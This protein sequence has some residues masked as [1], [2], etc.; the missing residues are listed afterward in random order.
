[1]RNIKF[2][3]TYLFEKFL[4]YFN[5]NDNKYWFE[6]RDPKDDKGYSVGWG[7]GNIEDDNYSKFDR[8]NRNEQFLIFSEIRKIFEK[9][10]NETK[11]D[12]F[13]FSVP[14]EKRLRIYISYLMSVIGDE[15]SHE[16]IETEYKPFDRSESKVYYGVFKK[17]I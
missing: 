12:S 7:V 14:G 10:F 6:V 15:Y 3:R 11:P 9:W 8:T 5:V 13:Y 16:I 17:K 1:M 4:Q 2:Y